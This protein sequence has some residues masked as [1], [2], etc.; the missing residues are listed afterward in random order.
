MFNLP[1]DGWSMGRG[2]VKL[3]WG[4]EVGVGPKSVLELSAIGI[5]P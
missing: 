4:V 2:V 3:G 1:T 5:Q